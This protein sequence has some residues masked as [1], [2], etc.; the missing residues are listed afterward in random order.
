MPKGLRSA[1]LVMFW[2]VGSA[3]FLL[4]LIRVWSGETL[5]PS[6]QSAACGTAAG[7]CLLTAID[8]WEKWR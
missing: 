7:F 4:G 6:L 1:A 5:S 3:S 8:A 2:A